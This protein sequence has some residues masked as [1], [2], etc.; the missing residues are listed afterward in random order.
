MWEVLCT[1]TDEHGTRSGQT[2]QGSINAGVAQ[3]L[4]NEMR[5]RYGN[6]STRF[7]VEWVPSED[8]WNAY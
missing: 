6:S 5:A 8:E 1:I 2:G 3:N 4:A 7:Y